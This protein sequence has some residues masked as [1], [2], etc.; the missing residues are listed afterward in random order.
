MMAELPERP[1]AE[2]RAGVVEVAKAVFASFLGIRRRAKSESDAVRITPLQIVVAG[3]IGAVLFV[4]TI[5]FV[6]RLVLRAAGA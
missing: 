5:V 1:Q 3:L 4:L 6:V 2:A